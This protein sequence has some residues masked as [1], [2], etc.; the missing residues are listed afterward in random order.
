[1][2][3]S[4]DF[5]WRSEDRGSAVQGFVGHAKEASKKCGLCL[6]GKGTMEDILDCILKN[7]SINHVG[8]K[9]EEARPKAKR[10]LRRLFRSPGYHLL[11]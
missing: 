2:T 8:D 11:L 9:L 5:A 4:T 7:H 6:V 1:M 10:S 3:D